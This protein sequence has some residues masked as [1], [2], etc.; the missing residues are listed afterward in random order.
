MTT[1]WAVFFSVVQ[2]VI[3]VVVI[4]FRYPFLRL[5][6]RLLTRWYGPA[7]AED[8]TDPRVAPAIVAAGIFFIAIG[9][10]AGFEALF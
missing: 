2:V 7:V 5:G 9:V 10:A 1:S 6:R 8:A 4:V 3:G